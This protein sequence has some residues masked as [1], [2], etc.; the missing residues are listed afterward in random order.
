MRQLEG[1]VAFVT[2]AASG[3]GAAS[4][5]ALA[6]EGAAVVVSDVDGVRAEALVETLTGSG[7]RAMALTQDVTD[8]AGWPEAVRAVERRFGRLDVMIANAGVAVK[9][10]VTEMSLKAWRQQTAINLDGVFLSAKYAI[11]AMKR[12]GGGSIIVMSSVAGL[13]GSSGFSGYCASKG[14][15]RLFAKALALECAGLGDNIR[16]NS[17]HPGV[18]DTPLWDTIP[19]GKDGLGRRHIDAARMGHNDA[20]MGRAGTADE[21]ASCVVFLA[22]DSSS[23][24]T[25]AEVVLDGGITAGAMPRR[26]I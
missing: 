5:A 22:S 1:K 14:G 25:G 13:R 11:P 9:G 16:V 8:E 12:S 20:P 19:L 26:K 17:I 7:S 23:Y 21:V 3:I 6:R 10:L 18:I 2:G 4:A 15:A 24:M